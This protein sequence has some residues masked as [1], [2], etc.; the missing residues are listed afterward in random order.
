MSVARLDFLLSDIALRSPDGGWIGALDRQEYISLREGRDR[1]RLDGLP[2][3]RFDRV[4]FS[5]GLPDELNNADP[6]RFPPGHPLNPNVNGL[7]WS[8]LGG[9]VFLALRGAGPAP[10]QPA[11]IPTTWPRPRCARPSRSWSHLDLATD[12]TQDLRIDLPRVFAGL[13]IT[14]ENSTTHSR[15]GDAV[16]TLLKSNLESAFS[17]GEARLG[18]LFHR[19]GVAL[20]GLPPGAVPHPFTFPAYF[21]RPSLP[22]DNP[23]TEQGVALGRKLFHDPLL[24]ATARSPAPPATTRSRPSPIPAASAPASAGPPASATPCPLQLPGRSPSSGTVARPP[25]ANRPCIPSA[26]PPRWAIRPGPSPPAR[27]GAGRPCPC[28]LGDAVTTN[29]LAPRR[30]SS[31]SIVSADAKFDRG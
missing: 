30:S 6:D 22:A 19:P 2:T 28:R 3:G 17:A 7:H 23:L 12:T 13:V 14:R 26:T 16:A 24:S 27:L 25:P 4:R 20:A 31:C 29:R 10:R 15:K 8:W 11:G 18:I 21:P 5:I 9:Y 1:L